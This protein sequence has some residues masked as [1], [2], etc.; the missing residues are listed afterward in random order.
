MRANHRSGLD[1]AEAVSQS[2]LEKKDFCAR[3]LSFDL[4]QHRL[5]SA[6]VAM[7]RDV[8]AHRTP[9]IFVS[10]PEDRIQRVAY[11]N[12]LTGLISVPC[13]PLYRKRKRRCVLAT[14]LAHSAVLRRIQIL[15]EFPNSQIH[16]MRR[17][18]KQITYRHKIK[19]HISLSKSCVQ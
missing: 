10:W 8:G 14:P 15:H 13:S 2:Q 12:A 18:N 4:D 17:E 19:F 6:L 3:G 9:N 5:R 11:A 16:I 7:L 1:V